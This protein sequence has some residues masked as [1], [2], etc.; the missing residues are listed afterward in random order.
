M[1]NI[2]QFSLV[3]II[4]ISLYF[5]YN[6][7][8]AKDV[9]SSIET[10]PADNE[11]LPKNTNNQIKNLR[12]EV[13]LDNNNQYIITSNFSELIN[14]NEYEIVKMQGVEAIFIE[15]EKIPILIKSDNADYNNE[16]YNTEFKNNV[17][18]E[19]M[20]SKIFSDKLNIDFKKNK[21]RIFE[22]VLYE[23]DHGKMKT[24]NIVINL[25]T[26]EIDISMQNENK[27][28]E[29]IKY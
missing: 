5:I 3:C 13:N 25:T 15:K 10:L 2:I 11:F 14:S 20:D 9:T 26:K 7:Y 12:Y 4:G 27:N 8:L 23:G 1:K 17:L 22:N 21:I 18:I 29:L 19:Y 16:N 24:D 28:V 6:T